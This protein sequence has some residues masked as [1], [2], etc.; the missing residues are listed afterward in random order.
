MVPLMSNAQTYGMLR[1]LLIVQSCNF[2][3]FTVKGHMKWQ[4][5]INEVGYWI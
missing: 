4:K 1:R 2:K 3:H 5:K